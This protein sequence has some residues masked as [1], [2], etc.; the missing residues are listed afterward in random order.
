MALLQVD[1]VEAG[2]GGDL[3]GL[4]VAVLEAVEFVVGDQRG[5]GV[6]APAGPAI[7]H[8]PRV[9]G[10]IVLGKGRSGDAVSARMRELE[11]D[12]Q[13]GVVAPGVAVGRSAGLQQPGEAVEVFGVAEQLP[14]VGAA[15]GDDGGGLAPDE[16]RA[17]VAEATI[18]TERQLAGMAVVGG[19]A[20]FHR[21]DRQAVAD[22]TAADGD[23]P[24]ERLEVVAQAEVEPQGPGLVEQGLG[25]LVLEVARHGRLRR[26]QCRSDA[27]D[28]F[29]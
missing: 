11:A 22:V 2:A 26:H 5:L 9:E 1:E 17:A 3:G 28:R 27:V 25:G 15:F 29:S 18:A 4:D 23:R 16:F 7:D 12:E 8:G 20:A 24:G 13:V 21:V 10:A 6:G 19:V 14:G